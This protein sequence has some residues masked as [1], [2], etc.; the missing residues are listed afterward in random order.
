MIRCIEYVISGQAEDYKAQM[1]E[2]FLLLSDDMQK[3]VILPQI[4]QE[5][6]PLMHMEIL[7]D[8]GAWANR[9]ACEFFRKDKITGVERQQWQQ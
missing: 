3:E 2:R 1:E 5:Q 9:V 7:D 6:G 4:N 8:P